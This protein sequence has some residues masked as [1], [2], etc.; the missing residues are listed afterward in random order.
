MKEGKVPSL[1]EQEG[2]AIRQEM[3]KDNFALA[4]KHKKR[5]KDY[6]LVHGLASTESIV[7]SEIPGIKKG[8]GVIRDRIEYSPEDE[9]LTRVSVNYSPYSEP[10][11]VEKYPLPHQSD[12]V[13]YGPSVILAATKL[14]KARG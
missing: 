12:W 10:R 9:K 4:E 11:V 13:M 3:F 5:I 2:D 1:L 7:V 14:M 8:P 6:L